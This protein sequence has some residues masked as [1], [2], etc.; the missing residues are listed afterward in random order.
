[1]KGQIRAGNLVIAFI[2]LAFVLLGLFNLYAGFLVDHD[3][4]PDASMETAVNNLYVDATNKGDEAQNLSEELSTQFDSG[5]NI[6]IRGSK[7]LQ[8][9]SNAGVIALNSFDI[10]QD[11][12]S[13]TQLPSEFYFTLGLIVSLLFVFAVAG[14]LWKFDLI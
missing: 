12:T 6:F 13:E 4:T 11:G 7:P 3:V 10:L 5:D 2:V 9:I 1:M 14:A 8:A